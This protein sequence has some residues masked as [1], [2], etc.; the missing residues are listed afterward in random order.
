MVI[1][2]AKAAGPYAAGKQTIPMPEYQRFVADFADL[3]SVLR[4]Q[5]HLPYTAE[6]DLNVEDALLRCSGMA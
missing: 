3:A 6:M 2:L 5:G 4:G 1:D